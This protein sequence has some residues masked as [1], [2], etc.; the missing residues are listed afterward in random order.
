MRKKPITSHVDLGKTTPLLGLTQY[1]F[2]FV[3][4]TCTINPPSNQIPI[5]K[6]NKTHIL[7]SPIASK[8]NL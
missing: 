5:T 3:V 6:R 7:K 8:I 1:F 4:L 2:G